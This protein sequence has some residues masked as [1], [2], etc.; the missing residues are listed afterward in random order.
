M[1][2][3]NRCQFRIY[4]S[5]LH[6]Y[7]KVRKTAKYLTTTSGKNPGIILKW[8]LTDHRRLKADPAFL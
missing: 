6:F 3:R 4:S 2:A 5:V 8:I 7:V 1:N